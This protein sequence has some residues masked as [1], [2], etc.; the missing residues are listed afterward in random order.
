MRKELCFV[1]GMKCFFAF[2]FDHNRVVHD[3]I[4]TEA[5]IQF[6]GAVEH[7]DRSLALD[8]KAPHLKFVGDAGFVGG[9]EQPWPEC[10]MHGDR[11]TDNAG[12]DLRGMHCS[13]SSAGG[14][15]SV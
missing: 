6:D 7:R 9:F 14:Q 12:G 8:L 1:H 15:D 4:G 10:A 5:T 13:N 2:E 3:K 11:G